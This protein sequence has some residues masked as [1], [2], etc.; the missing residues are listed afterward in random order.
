[1]GSNELPG[2]ISL[3]LGRSCWSTMSWSFFTNKQTIDESGRSI[4]G[5][6]PVDK[7]L[8]FCMGL[9]GSSTHPQV[10]NCDAQSSEAVAELLLILKLLVKLAQSKA[11]LGQDLLRV[12]QGSQ[13]SR[14]QED[15]VDALDLVCQ[16]SDALC[17]MQTPPVELLGRCLH[18]LTSG[19]ASVR[20]GRTHCTFTAQSRSI[21]RRSY[22]WAISRMSP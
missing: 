7:R 4:L 11:T 17:Q 21:T 16:I 8:V 9:I 1:M 13:H 20:H 6:V 3:P 5:L 19:T 14:A 15:G 2:C 22:C 18:M 10:P 12:K